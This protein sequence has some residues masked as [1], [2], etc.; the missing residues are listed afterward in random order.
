MAAKTK[1]EEQGRVSAQAKAEAEV[2]AKDSAAA[3]EAAVEA[4]EVVELKRQQSSDA[5]EAAAEAAKAKAEASEGLK[6]AAAEVQTAVAEVKRASMRQSI[7]LSQLQGGGYE[8]GGGFTLAEA[9]EMRVKRKSSAVRMIRSTLFRAPTELLLGRRPTDGLGGLAEESWLSS[10]SYDDDMGLHHPHVHH[11]H[12]HHH[13]PMSLPRR[14]AHV[15]LGL[16][17]LS[18]RAPHPRRPP[19][20]PRTPPPRLATR[21]RGAARARRSSGSPRATGRSST[22]A[23]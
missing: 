5:E 1:A 14:A 15:A 18:V 9:S 23:C 19:S 11:H 7:A 8:L 13:A 10:D 22:R 17:I 21:P 2:R 6:A 16:I 3:I 4:A 12:A 20:P